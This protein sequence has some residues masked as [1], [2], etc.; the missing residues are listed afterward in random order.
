MFSLHIWLFGFARLG[1]LF[2]LR[3]R[4]GLYRSILLFTDGRFCRFCRRHPGLS[5]EKSMS[6][7]ILVAYPPP[8]S[9]EVMDK[10][11]HFPQNRYFSSTAQF[12]TLSVAYF[13]RVKSYNKT[14]GTKGGFPCIKRK[15]TCHSPADIVN[16]CP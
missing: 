12:S 8:G 1:G 9:H 11:G 14:T 5:K 7:M 6:F 15:S 13:A 3:G 16:Y 2:P 10:G 4:W